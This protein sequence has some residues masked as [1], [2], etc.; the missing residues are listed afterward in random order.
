MSQLIYLICITAFFG[1][2]ILYNDYLHSLPNIKQSNASKPHQ[3]KQDVIKRPL[4]PSG[5]LYIAERAIGAKLEDCPMESK[6]Y[7]IK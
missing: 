4:F 6:I 3:P 5:H 7:A 2:Y 1:F